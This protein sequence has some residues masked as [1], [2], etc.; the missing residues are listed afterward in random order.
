VE[1]PSD[2]VPGSPL[3][4]TVQVGPSPLGPAEA[5]EEGPSGRL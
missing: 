1:A 2:A 3:N 5:D 4:Q